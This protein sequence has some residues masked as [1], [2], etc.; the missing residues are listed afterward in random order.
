MAMTI[1]MAIPIPMGTAGAF[2]AR[3]PGSRLFV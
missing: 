2:N 1:S 3:G